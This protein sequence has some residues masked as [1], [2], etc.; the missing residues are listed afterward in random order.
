MYI[1]PMTRPKL[2]EILLF[3]GAQPIDVSG[4][5]Q[6]FITAND[7]S[8]AEAY[9]IHLTAV[10]STVAVLSGGMRVLVDPPVVGPIDMLLVPGGPGVYGARHA[11]PLVRW[12]REA[13]NRAERVCSICTGAFLLAEAGLLDGRKVATHWRSCARLATEYPQVTVMPDPIWIQDG[14]VWTSAGVTAGIDLALAIIEK[15]L[16]STIALRVARRLVVYMRRSGGQTQHSEPLKFQE[17]DAF[18]PVL[19][20]AIANLERSITV[21]DLA[22]RAG[23]TPRTFHRQ[24]LTRTGFTPAKALERL[25]VDQAKTLL[26]TTSL[27]FQVVATKVGFRAEE[28][29]RRSFQRTIGITP[30]EYRSRFGARQ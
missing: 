3:D 10:D 4:P 13:A 2:I 7:E 6:A 12:V 11:A 28:N 20:W 18:T 16:G 19:E 29:F 9:A 27:S 5:M 22:A 24:F 14:D 25:R 15:D 23:M 8:G 26:D 1:L 30:Y 21:E 17:A